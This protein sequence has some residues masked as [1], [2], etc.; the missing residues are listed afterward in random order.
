MKTT[1]YFSFYRFS[2]FK[3]KKR[4]A[5]LC[6][7]LPICHVYDIEENAH[8]FQAPEGRHIGSEEQRPPSLIF[9]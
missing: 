3:R 6:L 7:F 4:G 9:L 8:G 1:S 5:G 2:M